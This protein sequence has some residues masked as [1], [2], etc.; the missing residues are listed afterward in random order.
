MDHWEAIYEFN[1]KFK[2]DV[3]YSSGDFADQYV[4][5]RFPKAT[6]ADNGRI[7][8]LK[9][10]PQV[11]KIAK[12]FPAIKIMRGNH[13]QRI[14]KRA[15]A[16]GIDGVWVRDFLDMVGAPK[17]WEWLPEDFVNVGPAVLTHGFLANREKHAL[18][19]NRNVV[20]G[21]LHAKLGLEF[22]QR[23]NKVIWAMCIGAIADKKAMALQY[24]AL[25]KFSTMTCGFGTTDEEGTPQV[26]HL[27]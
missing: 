23:N 8:V 1:K 14:N 12:M 27:G 22:F 2:A 9:C 4:L 7:E 24:G 17:S 19:F 11:R 5:S 16:A 6:N 20:H 26:Y 25:P 10:I 3:V 21:H 15:Q 13:D 18:F